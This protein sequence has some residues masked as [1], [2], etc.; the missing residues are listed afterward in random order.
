MMSTSQE[1]E[2]IYPPASLVHP[3]L[4]RKLNLPSTGDTQ[5]LTLD[6][7][8]TYLL[9]LSMK[10]HRSDLLRQVIETMDVPLLKKINNMVVFDSR[11]GCVKLQWVLIKK[12][13][14]REARK[15]GWY[16][17]KPDRLKR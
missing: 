3:S 4:A 6:Q 12:V 1:Q 2:T 16:E 8:N 17:D 15:G 10:E 14:Y 11:P 7:L 9:V 5:Q 13:G